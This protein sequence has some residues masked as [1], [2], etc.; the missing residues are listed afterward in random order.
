MTGEIVHRNVLPTIW[1]ICLLTE[2]DTL[3][4]VVEKFL[5]LELLLTVGTFVISDLFMEIFD[6]VIQVLVFLVTD[7][8]G[9]GLR[10]MYLLD[11]VLQS[12]LCYKLLLTQRTF[13]DLEK[14]IKFLLFVIQ[15]NHELSIPC[16]DNAP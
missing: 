13:S 12:I 9:R 16:C 3:H 5:G 15:Y 7:V 6:M 1:T 2:M 11:V 10:Q 8:T 4:V 14:I